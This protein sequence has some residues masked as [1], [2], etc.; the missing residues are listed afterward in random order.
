ME[1]IQLKSRPTAHELGVNYVQ[2][3][4]D[5]AG[6]SIRDVNE[7]LDSPYQL[8]AEI[9]D[10]ALLIAIRTAYHPNVGKIDNET[11]RKLISESV[12]LNAIPHF[13]GLSLTSM[14]GSDIQV[15]GFGEGEEYNVIFHGMTVVR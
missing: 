2:D 3:L 4:L 7:A 5:R 10:K 12:R 8:F 9:N 14:S 13:A 11:Q 15:E 1:H 6:F